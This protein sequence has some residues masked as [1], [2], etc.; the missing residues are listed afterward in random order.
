MVLEEAL[1]MDIPSE[2][3]LKLRTVGELVDYL[4]N[5]AKSRCLPHR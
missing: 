4:S 3:L 1:S 2:G 5:T